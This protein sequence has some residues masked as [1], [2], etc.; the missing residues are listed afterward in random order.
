VRPAIPPGRPM[1]D[2]GA[3]LMTGKLRYCCDGFAGDSRCCG[4]A[5][6]RGTDSLRTIPAC[7]R[8]PRATA[9]CD[10]TAHVSFCRSQKL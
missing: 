4:L 3:P 6:G 7:A 10:P 5:G 1:T 9:A 2:V 8:W